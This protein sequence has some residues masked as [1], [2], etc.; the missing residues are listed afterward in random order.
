MPGCKVHDEALGIDG[1]YLIYGRTFERS[2]QDG[3][4]T[5]LKL[6]PPGLVQ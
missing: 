1:V 6:G 2:K 5:S 3:T 4:F